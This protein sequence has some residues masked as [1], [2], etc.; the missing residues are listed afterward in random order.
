MI[1][2]SMAT[3]PG[4]IDKP[5]E[6]WVAANP[7]LIVV[8]DGSTARTDTGCVLGAGVFERRLLVRRHA[9]NQHRR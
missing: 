6:D 1:R 3:E 5:N 9:R 7:S 4:D 8:L 2:L